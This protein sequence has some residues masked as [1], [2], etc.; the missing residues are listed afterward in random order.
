[1]K[2]QVNA[3]P[4]IIQLSEQMDGYTLRL[5][6][7]SR[8]WLDEQH[9]DPARVSSIFIGFDKAAS[10]DQ[11]H[12]SIWYQVAYLLTSLSHEELNDLGGFAVINPTSGQEIFHSLLV[13]A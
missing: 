6:P 1:M 3:P 11:I 12:E 13:H 9:P 10:V 4:V 7:R 5:R 8:V 2:M